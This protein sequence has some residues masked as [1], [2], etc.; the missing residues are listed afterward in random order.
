MGESCDLLVKLRG[1]I[2]YEIEN[3]NKNE[4]GSLLIPKVQHD[5]HHRI[6]F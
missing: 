5:I 1:Y 6:I 2:F 3:E 4:N